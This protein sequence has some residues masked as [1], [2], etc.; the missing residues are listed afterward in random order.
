MHRFVIIG[1]GGYRDPTGIAH[2]KD[3][4]RL[5]RSVATGISNKSS[6]I[7]CIH[8]RVQELCK[9]RGDHPGLSVLTSLMVSVDIN[10]Y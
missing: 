8:F 6:N 9:S 1:T 5:H 7:D 2:L 3:E 10:Q 4:A